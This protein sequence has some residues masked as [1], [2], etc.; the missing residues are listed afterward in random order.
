MA[1]VAVDK[2]GSEYVYS[3][4]PYRRNDEDWWSSRNDFV[5]LPKGTIEKL[6]GRHLTWKD[7]P[8]ELKR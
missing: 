5:P 3:N 2:D 4:R 6:I 1:F 8:V 7:D